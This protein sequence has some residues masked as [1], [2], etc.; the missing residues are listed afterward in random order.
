MSNA[1]KYSFENNKIEVVVWEKEKNLY[2]SVKDFGAGVSIEN[3][4]IIYDRFKRLDSGINSINRG[5]GLGL[6]INKALLDLLNGEI[7]IQSE[8]GKGAKFTITIP[9]KER[10]IEGYASDG[11][12]LFFDIDDEKQCDDKEET[13]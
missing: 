13:F 9:E 12:E 2:V 4:K 5:H 1:V 8:I 11:N 7:D 10:S 6:S 3:Q